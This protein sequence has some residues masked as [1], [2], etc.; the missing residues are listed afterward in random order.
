[1][2]KSCNDKTMK[3]H[4]STHTQNENVSNI[5]Y[6]NSLSNTLR[7]IN[8]VLLLVDYP[9]RWHNIYPAYKQCSVFS[10]GGGGV[11]H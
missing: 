4:Y 10:G 5:D 3:K 6:A 7:L 2:A 8:V 9:W 1:M 11:T